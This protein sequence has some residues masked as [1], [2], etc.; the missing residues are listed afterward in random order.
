MQVVQLQLTAIGQIEL[1]LL[2]VQVAPAELI[3]VQSGG[4]FS[5]AEQGAASD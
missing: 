3:Q 5:A 4:V 1:Q 2:Q